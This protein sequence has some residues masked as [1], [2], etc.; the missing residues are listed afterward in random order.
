M[1]EKLLD[2]EQYPTLIKYQPEKIWASVKKLQEKY[3]DMTEQQCLL[4]LE[5]DLAQID[6][7]A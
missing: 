1:E 7:I 2:K 4:N 3:P 6:Q 5:M